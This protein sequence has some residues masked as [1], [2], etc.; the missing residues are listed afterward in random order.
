MGD[1][2]R[3]ARAL[4]VSATRKFA[5]AAE[6]RRRAARRDVEP[7]VVVEE[8]ETDEEEE[9]EPSPEV[10][11]VVPDEPDIRQQRADAAESRRSS[12]RA[13]EAQLEAVAIPE[14]TPPATISSSPFPPRPFGARRGSENGPTQS[15]VSAVPIPVIDSRPA[16]QASTSRLPPV[17]PPSRPVRATI[18]R[19]LPSI[20]PVPSTTLQDGMELVNAIEPTSPPT[21][22]TPQ[23]RR[24][25]PPPPTQR[26]NSEPL[27][28]SPTTPTNALSRNHTR[29]SRPLPKPPVASDRID[30][31]SALFPTR[32][33]ASSPS[34]SSDPSSFSHSHLAVPPPPLSTASS[35]EVTS[36]GLLPS[37]GERDEFVYT[38][39]DL[40]LAR[41]EGPNEDGTNYDVSDL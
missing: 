30:A 27:T 36:P 10:T 34:N 38:D 20:L 16:P 4:S 11:P 37:E 29:P 14:A 7:V 12:E 18:S 2:P 15:T 33:R 1:G 21:N 19:T 40:L 23:R 35:F 6:R 41:L 3:L 22:L 26:S 25:A 39:L 9:A 24:P 13:R 28:P 31:F 17:P 5:E 32:S 8:E